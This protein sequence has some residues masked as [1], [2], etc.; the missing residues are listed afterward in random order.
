EPA[1]AWQAA[2]PA[3]WRR[4]PDDWP[5]T[6]YEEKAVAAGR[7]PVFLRFLRRPRRPSEA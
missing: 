1:L 2:G 6:R 4:R 3:D 7:R 5:P